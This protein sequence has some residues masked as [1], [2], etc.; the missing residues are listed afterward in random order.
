MTMFNVDVYFLRHDWVEWLKL[1]KAS[2]LLEISL[3]IPLKYNGAG[4]LLSI[5]LRFN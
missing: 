3:I 1:E 4:S 5:S 2:I